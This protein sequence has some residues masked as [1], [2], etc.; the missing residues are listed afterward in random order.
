M[1]T[2]KSHEIIN[3]VSIISTIF[4]FVLLLFFW[5]DLNIPKKILI[6]SF[7]CLFLYIMLKNSYLKR[8][9]YQ[10]KYATIDSAIKKR[11][12]PGGETLNGI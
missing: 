5:S 10:K 3:L 11:S 1:Q 7:I 2:Q 8:K 6:F 9:K 4:G 12:G